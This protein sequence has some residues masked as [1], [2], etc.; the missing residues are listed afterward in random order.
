MIA[1]TLGRSFDWTGRAT[2]KEVWAF[3]LFSAGLLV[4][5]FFAEVRIADDHLMLPRLFWIVAAALVPAQISLMIRRA[6]DIGHS[7]RWLLLCLVPLVGLAA[8]VWLLLAPSGRPYRGSDHPRV[9]L[10]GGLVVTI[11][12]TLLVASRAFWQPYSVPSGSMKPTLLIGDRVIAWRP[13]AYAPERGDMVVFRHP[14]QPID[15]IRRVIGLP[16]DTVQMK[17]GTVW[18]NGAPLPQTDAGKFSELMAPQGPTMARPICS[19]AP[20]GDGGTCLNELK[21]ETMPDGK[22]HAILNTNTSWL[23]NSQLFTVPTGYYFVMGD[24]RD[25]SMD[26]RALADAGGVGMIPADNIIGRVNRVA[27]STAG[28]RDYAVWTL[29]PERIFKRIE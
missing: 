8:Q 6:H 3:L 13:I 5:V 15:Y 7:G 1:Q 26:S 10:I 16:G 24:N 23:D 14:R 22:S 9:A 29:R 11:G 2:R 28:R 19:N 20:V 4:A 12:L 17:D 27:Y 21:I 25:F 18:L